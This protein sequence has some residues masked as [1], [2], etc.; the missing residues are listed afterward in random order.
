M[1]SQQVS[2]K[3]YD[4]FD[5]GAYLDCLYEEVD[6]FHYHSLKQIHEIFKSY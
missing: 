3:D 5:P 4:M 1:A 6:A 2:G